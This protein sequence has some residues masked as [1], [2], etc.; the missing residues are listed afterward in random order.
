LC[1]NARIQ[2]LPDLGYEAIQTNLPM[3]VVPRPPMSAAGRHEDDKAG[4]PVCRVAFRRKSIAYQAPVRRAGLSV[5]NEDRA[6]SSSSA[7]S[8]NPAH[9]DATVVTHPRNELSAR[10]QCVIVMAGR[11]PAIH[12]FL[13]TGENRGL[14]RQKTWMAAT[15]AAMTLKTRREFVTHLC[16]SHSMRMA[17]PT[18]IPRGLSTAAHK[19]F[20]PAS[21]S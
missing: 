10:C 5:H 6:Y 21:D 1:R 9:A 12:V 16:D 13:P 14:P 2:V 4:Q 3:R 11:V 18:E 15:R 8:Q 19:T 20:Q 7:P 17:E